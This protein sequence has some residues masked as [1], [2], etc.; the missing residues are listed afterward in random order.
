MR[1]F[2]HPPQSV[3]HM[4]QV[5]KKSSLDELFL[6]IP[7]SLQ[8]KQP[9]H[10]PKSM[11]EMQI[12]R[13]LKTYGRDLGL[14]IF[15]GA[16]ACQHF[17]PQWVF[18]QMARAEWYTAYTPYQ[19]EVS[20][21]TLQAIFEF[22]SVVSSLFGLDIANAS[23]YDGATALAEAILMATRA[24]GHKDVAISKLIHPEYRQS[25]QT[26]LE[27]IG[28]KL[29]EIDF[30]EHGQTCALHTKK[31]FS[32]GINFAC[33]CLASPN[34]LGIMENFSDLALEAKKHNALAIGVNSDVSI[35]ALSQ[36]FGEL[37]ADI[38][39][40][41]GLGFV[42]SLNMGGPG[43]GLL[44]CK[45]NLLRQLPGRLAGLTKDS[46]GKHGFT[47]TLSTR[48]QHIRREKATS[49]ICTNHNLMALAFLMTMTSYGRAGL[50]TL[51]T[52]NLKKTLYFRKL[53]KKSPLKIKFLGPHYNETVVEF[54]STKKLDE[55]YQKAREKGLVA[56]VKLGLFYPS[57]A[58]CLLVNTTEM[59]SD[60]E[61]VLLASIIFG[62]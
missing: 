25:L 53:I 15:A 38:A 3:Q 2:N 51:A 42:G 10:I 56:G 40:G 29:W 49:N 20:Q 8:L 32:S 35:F 58:N 41:E 31:I 19:P 46:Q 22:Q 27:P 52:I 17:V 39:V 57:L 45:Q 1:Y 26:Y 23:M 21:G 60:Q 50:R 24:T 55:A 34:F 7:K 6:S 48:E 54:E 12:K 30:N 4:L 37:Q 16:G 59:H 14:T 36:S 11:D 18:E 9:L 33:L 44:A 13:E 61:L 47:L 62:K 43:V 5:L 28:I